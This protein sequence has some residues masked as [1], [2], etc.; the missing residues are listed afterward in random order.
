MGEREREENRKWGDKSVNFHYTKLSFSSSFILCHVPLFNNNSLYWM[1]IASEFFI[2]YLL[3]KLWH[4]ID[5]Y[6]M[7]LE[8]S[9][10]EIVENEWNELKWIENWENEAIEWRQ[11]KSWAQLSRV[12]MKRRMRSCYLWQVKKLIS[13][14]STYFSHQ[15]VNQR[16][17][18]WRWW[19]EWFFIAVKSRLWNKGREN[20]FKFVISVD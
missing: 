9:M 5:T 16:W 18:R 10:V 19:L 12:V 20:W 11:K 14:C 6:S 2:I 4:I 8:A 1:S 13:Y 15:S 7:W 17:W 3:N